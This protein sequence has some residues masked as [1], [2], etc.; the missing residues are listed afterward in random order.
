MIKCIAQN[1][2]WCDHFRMLLK[3]L[4]KPALGFVILAIFPTL[5]ITLPNVPLVP[6]VIFANTFFSSMANPSVNTFC[7]TPYGL[8][9]LNI[10][11]RA[12]AL[13]NPMILVDK[14]FYFDPNYFENFYSAYLNSCLRRG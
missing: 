2:L 10:L 8:I 1:K 4:P 9:S 7:S 14:S 6:P 5:P 11:W 12:E 13:N 3:I